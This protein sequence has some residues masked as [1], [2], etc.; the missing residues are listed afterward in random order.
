MSDSINDLFARLHELDIKL[1]LDEGKLRCNAPQGVLT[2]E[3]QSNLTVRKQEIIDYLAKAAQGS[4]L[5]RSAHLIK[6][7]QVFISPFSFTD[8]LKHFEEPLE[9]DTAWNTLAA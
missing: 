9:A 8:K 2:S 5:D 6:K 7:F 4:V 1:W 3:L